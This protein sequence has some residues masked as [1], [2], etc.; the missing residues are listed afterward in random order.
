MKSKKQKM[1]MKGYIYV[2]DHP[3]YEQYGVIKLGQTGNIGSREFTYRTGEFIRGCFTVVFEVSYMIKSTLERN[4]QRY[5]RKYHRK[6]TGGNEFY[7]NEII[8]L[9]E[10]Y[11]KENGIE[12]RLM[13]KEEIE[14]MISDYQ[15]EN[16]LNI[17][18][19]RLL[20]YV[21]ERRIKNVKKKPIPV[22]QPRPYQEEIINKSLK[23][24][25]EVDNKGLLVLMCGVGKTL[26]SLWITQRLNANKILIGVPNLLLLKQWRNEIKRVYK[27]FKSSDILVISGDL[28]EYEMNRFFKTHSG[29]DDK[30][31]ILTTY[32]S[33]F[34]VFQMS[35]R[36]N[37][38]FDMKILDE[39]H[40]IT[41]GDMR[42]I[43]VETSRQY[44]MILN[45]SSKRQLA[46]TAT[47]KEIQND[48]VEAEVVSNTSVD[49]YGQIIDRRCLYWAIKNE[50]VC[51]YEIQIIETKEKD[52]EENYEICNVESNDKRLF[53]A[54]Y[55]A[56][57]SL[58]KG[59]SHHI[60]IYCNSIVN[61]NKVVK[62][63][64]R[65][66]KLQ[67]FEYLKSELFYDSYHSEKSDEELIE[68]M[69]KFKNSGKG[70]FTCVYGLGE[71]WDFPTLDAVVFAENMTSSIRIVQSALRSGRKNKHEQNKKNKLIIPIMD[72]KDIQDK[73]E[74][75]YARIREVVCQMGWEDETVIEKIRILQ[76]NSE[77][78]TGGGGGG[79]IPSIKPHPDLDEIQNLLN[80][81][82]NIDRPLGI[83]FEKAKLIIQMNG[84]KTI[85][86]YIEFCEKD[87][88]F[89][90]RPDER[91]P[92]KFIGWTDYLSIPRIY[93]EKEECKRKIN[94][95][96][97]IY[98]DLMKY[99]LNISYVCD[100]LC[101]I[102][103]NFPPLEFWLSYYQIASL[104]EMIKIEVKKEKKKIII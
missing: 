76:N 24:Y 17:I 104:E 40:H 87:N 79:N 36:Y 22:L 18:K 4:L 52:I 58:L 99:R 92:N 34:K 57:T 47:L 91:Y 44:I 10:P 100:E 29:V 68:S 78:P 8:E 45:V 102:D 83:A 53:L 27:N 49:Y 71:G 19:H 81:L 66:L 51:N 77:D 60:L 65:L 9:I 20:N 26:I 32:A 41:C 13:E 95:Y 14:K 33:A 89:P 28:D 75:D 50:V 73:S 94:E 62:Y 39:C 31:I 2:R 103:N 96:L 25:Q 98:T 3:A 35:E 72:L 23:H 54:G 64:K 63:I 21:R 93:Y 6:G 88:R 84:I 42:E 15:L 56:L 37:M 59:D 80:G 90:Y 74:K 7:S 82:K 43:D 16:A 5:F 48:L 30:C 67:I 85:K 1:S 101:K 97:E 38:Y 11:L 69:L 70:I 86:E 46:L 61:T 12:Y 55:S